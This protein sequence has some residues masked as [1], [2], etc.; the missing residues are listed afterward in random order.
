VCEGHRNEKV[1]AL[2]CACGRDVEIIVGKWG[3]YGKCERCGNVSWSKLTNLNDV[4]V[5]TV[6]SESPPAQP[7]T[8]QRHADVPTQPREIT[9]RSD[10]VD[11]L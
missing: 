6:P 3:P 8:K 10:E 4:S 11:F 1:S 7:Y 5:S 2:R 9:I